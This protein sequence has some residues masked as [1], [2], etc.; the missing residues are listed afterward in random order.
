VLWKKKKMIFLLETF[1]SS[2]FSGRKKKLFF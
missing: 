2:F 1:K